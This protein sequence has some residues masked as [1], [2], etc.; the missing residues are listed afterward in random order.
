[1]NPL[2]VLVA[3]ELDESQVI[4]LPRAYLLILLTV[5]T[6]TGGYFFYAALNNRPHATHY[7]PTLPNTTQR[8][9]ALGFGLMMLLM[10]PARRGTFCG[11]LRLRD[12]IS[13]LFDER[14]CSP[15]G[16]GL[17]ASRAHLMKFSQ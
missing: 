4:R 17:D 7:H 12:Y 14:T 8:P 15:D 5:G 10:E 3:G 9:A 13:E 11:R 6:G 16:I 1:M 2:M